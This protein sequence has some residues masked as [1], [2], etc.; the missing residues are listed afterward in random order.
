MITTIY[1][2]RHG[3]TKYNKLEI[4]M[5]N[6]NAALNYTGKKNSK[7]IGKKLKKLKIKPDLIYS[8]DLQRA[9]QTAEIIAREIQFTKP[10]RKAKSLREINYGD[11]EGI[12]IK[13]ARQAVPE[14][15]S[16]NVNFTFP[17]G[18]SYSKMHKRVIKETRRIVKQNQGNTILIISH[19]RPLQCILCHYNK[20]KFKDELIKRKSHEWISHEYIG[21]LTI[22]N[23]KLVKYENLSESEVK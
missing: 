13:N 10:I 20:W 9:K 12:P 17:N 11:L 22:E 7:N 4:I 5:G 6:S 3:E 15:H 8:S 18:E 16:K 2:V 21:K 19:L 1:L 23:K 14:Y